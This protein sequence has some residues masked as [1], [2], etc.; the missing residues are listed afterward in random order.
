MLNYSIKHSNGETTIAF[1]GDLVVETTPQMRKMLIE[2][3]R[4][5]KDLLLDLGDVDRVDSSALAAFVEAATVAG[6]NGKS[7]ALGRVDETT[8][9]L[10]RLSRLNRVL[11]I[12][13]RKKETA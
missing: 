13:S 5:E 9:N 7:L 2:Q 1:S 6:A 4:K 8:F 11:Q 10:L 12:K 3:A